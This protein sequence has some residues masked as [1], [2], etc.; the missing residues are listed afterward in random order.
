[1]GDPDSTSP[2]TVVV[3]G[4]VS[5]EFSVDRPAAARRW[6]REGGGGA[7]SVGGGGV[8]EM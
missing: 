2:M 1:M 5:A 3:I 6:R 7:L 4:Y 8:A